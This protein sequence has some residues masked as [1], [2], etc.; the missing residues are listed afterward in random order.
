MR[1]CYHV[2]DADVAAAAVQRGVQDP[3]AR[4][5]AGGDGGDHGDAG[6]GAEEADVGGGDVEGEGEFEEGFACPWELGKR[7]V[8]C[9]VVEDVHHR[10]RALRRRNDMSGTVGGY[11]F[12]VYAWLGP[13]RVA[14]INAQLCRREEKCSCGG[15]VTRELTSLVSPA[16]AMLTPV[17]THHDIVSQ[18]F[19]T[20]QLLERHDDRRR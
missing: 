12:T 4:G 9:G 3:R 7:M 1:V 20:T 10:S 15:G 6:S 16:L 18:V 19:F 11:Y 13:L 2:A 17:C 5:E 8:R 14:R